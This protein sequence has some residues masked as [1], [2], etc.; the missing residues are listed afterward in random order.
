MDLFKRNRLRRSTL[1]ES[2]NWEDVGRMQFEFLLRE[3]LQPHHHL[4]DIG[5]GSFRGG[6]FVIDYLQEGHYFG[7]DREAQHLEAGM[8]HVLKP[9]NLTAKKP[10]IRVVELSAEPKD[11]REMLGHSRFDYI[12]IHAVFD[13]IPP[14]CIQRSLYDLAK[15]LGIPGRMYATFFLNPHGP[16]FREPIIHPRNGSLKGAVVT[17]PDREYWHHTIEFFEGVVS[18]IPGLKL[19][20]CLYDYPHPLG[21]RVLRLVNE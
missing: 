12:W 19:D 15:V 9:A 18:G 4:L 1:K 20:A 3:G 10:N 2:T 21:L 11:F 16:E 13:H 5:C 17:Y 14:D 7:I 6:R 8:K